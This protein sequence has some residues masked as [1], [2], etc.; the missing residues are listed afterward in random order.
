MSDSSSAPEPRLDALAETVAAIDAVVRGLGPRLDGVERLAGQLDEY[1][2]EQAGALAE[3]LP[4]VDQL[5]G[6]VGTGRGGSG[7]DSTDGSEGDS[8]PGVVWALL[9]AEEAVTAWDELARWVETVAIPTLEPTAREIPPCWP[10]HSWGRETMSWLHHAHRQA[11]GPHGSAFQVADWHTRWVP[12]A[13]SA[14]DSKGAAP[15]GY[16]AVGDHHCEQVERAALLRTEDWGPWLLRA[17]D[18][19]VAHRRTVRDS[20]G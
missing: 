12:Q 16:C 1:S 5:A 4:R 17:R 7:A 10:M 3:L 8:T 2:A 19:D 18:A 13:Y 11:Y 9:T 20:N 6:V 14:I 15:G